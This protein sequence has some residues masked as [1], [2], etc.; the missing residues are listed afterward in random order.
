M[1]RFNALCTAIV[2]GPKLAAGAA[3]LLARVG[4]MPVSRASDLVLSASPV[5][6]GALLRI[7]AVTP[8]HA[9]RALREQ[10]SFVV[11]ILGDDPWARK[12]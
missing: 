6:G 9:L 11:G 10:F 1:P 8:E 5:A 3:Q 12:W 2:L 4:E 7:V